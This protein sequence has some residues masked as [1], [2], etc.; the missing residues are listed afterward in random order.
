M[1]HWFIAYIDAGA[2]S[3]IV[4]ALIASVVAVPFYFRRQL[5]RAVRNFGRVKVRSDAPGR[6]ADLP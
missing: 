3:L 6:P 5:S 2:G 1:A 4:Q